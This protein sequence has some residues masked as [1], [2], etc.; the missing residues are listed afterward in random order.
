MRHDFE[1]AI[2]GIEK[3]DVDRKTHE[4]G[5]DGTRGAKEDPFAPRKIRATEQTA[6]A[7]N[8]VVSDV[9]AFTRDAVVDPNGGLT[10]AHL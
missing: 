10:V 3:H 1:D 2:V 9:A 7:G 4:E 6:H 5:V 8:G